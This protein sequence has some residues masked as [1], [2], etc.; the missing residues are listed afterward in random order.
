METATLIEPEVYEGTW[1]EIQQL[2]PKFDG[3]TLRVQVIHRPPASK[4]KL[5]PPGR[6]A[7]YLKAE[8]EKAASE[9]APTPEE[10]AAAEEDWKSFQRAM[11]ETRRQGGARI[12]F[13]DV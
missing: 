8:L 10:M 4:I 12:L 1:E 2:A 5:A 3:Q 11:N 9:P 13:P 6:L 7:A